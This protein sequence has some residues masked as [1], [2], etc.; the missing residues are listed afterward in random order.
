M[1]GLKEIRRRLKSVN[2]TK[3]ITSAMKLVSAAKLRKTQ[4]AVLRSRAYTDSLKGVLAQLQGGSEFTHPL[5]EPRQTVRKVRILV[6]GASRGLCGAFNT[7]INR[8]IESLYR[9]LTTKYPGC[10]V[11]SVLLGKKPAEY[12]RRIGR[13]YLEAV[14]NIADDPNAWPIQ[15]ICQKLEIDF[16]KGE[17]DE[18]HVVYTR[19]RSAISQTAVAERLLPLD[20]E[21]VAGSSADVGAAATGITLF[22]PNPQRVFDAV[23]PRIVRATVRQA[24]FDTKASEHASRMTAMDNATKN[25][26]ELIHSLTLKR[27]KLRQSGITS[28]LLD[29]VGGAE[30]LK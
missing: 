29:I 2:N 1:A 26:K 22:E 7:N 15:D 13:Q 24:A 14:E 11:S 23:V 6:L 9:E 16:I 18:L 28:Q 4:E 20:R 5:L 10:E 30:A 27:N 8:R 19:F 3:K 17:F 12:F 21:A 25:A